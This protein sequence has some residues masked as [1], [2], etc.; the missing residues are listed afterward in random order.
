MKRNQVDR[1]NLKSDDGG[2]NLSELR[3]FQS[4]L[5]REI[6]TSSLSD[7]NFFESKII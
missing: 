5:E 6:R 2:R 4:L 1:Y 7:E 3:I